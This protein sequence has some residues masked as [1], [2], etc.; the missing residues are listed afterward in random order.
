MKKYILIIITAFF[1]YCCTE[2]AEYTDCSIKKIDSDVTYRVSTITKMKGNDTLLFT[3][4]EYLG[5]NIRGG[6]QVTPSKD[7]IAEYYSYGFNTSIFMNNYDILPKKDP[8]TLPPDE[9]QVYDYVVK[10]KVESEYTEN[11][12]VG[13]QKISNYRKPTKEELIELGVEEGEYYYKYVI[14]NYEELYYEYDDNK[15]ITKIIEVIYKDDM[16][17]N[18]KAYCCNYKDKLIES[19]DIKL[20][21]NGWNIIGKIE[22]EYLNDRVI[23][24]IHP[25]YSISYEYG[26]KTINVK[27]VFKDGKEELYEYILNEKGYLIRENLPDGMSFCYTYEEGEGEGYFTQYKKIFNDIY[28]IPRPR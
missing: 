5:K 3:D 15:R 27:K 9:E 10:R 16:Q 18:L 24:I 7:T 2:E 20:Y 17:D 14:D 22:Y 6:E 23:K 11:Q 12:L 13:S 21:N 25:D 19:V 1:L 28:Y 4:I 26:D 8:N